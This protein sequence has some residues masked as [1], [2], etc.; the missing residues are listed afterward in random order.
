[1]TIQPGGQVEMTYKKAKCNG[2]I[3]AMH[4]ADMLELLRRLDQELSGV[5][6]LW[7]SDPDPIGLFEIKATGVKGSRVSAKWVADGSPRYEPFVAQL[8][9]IRRMLI[10][11]E[12]LT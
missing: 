1:M 9:R 6:R 8:Q 7:G 5:N 4:A 3:S 11:S 10:D 2:M 12:H